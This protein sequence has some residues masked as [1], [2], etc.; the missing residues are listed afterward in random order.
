[1]RPPLSKVS[2]LP[3]VMLMFFCWQ[4]PVSITYKTC[5]CLLQDMWFT[6]KS[7][8][9]ENK[10]KAWSGKERSIFYEQD[11]YYCKPSELATS[12]KGGVAVA[13]GLQVCFILYNIYVCIV[14]TLVVYAGLCQQRLPFV[15]W[16]LCHSSITKKAMHCTWS[17]Q[18]NSVFSWAFNL[19]AIYGVKSTVPPSHQQDNDFLQKLVLA[20]SII[21]QSNSKFLISRWS[22]YR[23]KIWMLRE[24]RPHY[25]MVQ[26]FPMIDA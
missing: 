11:S 14:Q 9:R 8:T 18:R 23:Y 24:R 20:H 7:L 25:Q 3:T 19:C 16:L 5:L 15:S 13:T 2:R 21:H 26:K 17:E 6:E 22:C 4:S 10:F 12:G 1:M